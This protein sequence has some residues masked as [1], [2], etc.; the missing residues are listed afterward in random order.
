M[1]ES[2]VSINSLQY[3]DQHI[4]PRFRLDTYMALSYTLISYSLVKLKLILERQSI[5]IMLILVGIIIIV[6]ADVGYKVFKD[7]DITL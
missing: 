7:L 4:L 2:V 5:M 3:F 1:S 6:V